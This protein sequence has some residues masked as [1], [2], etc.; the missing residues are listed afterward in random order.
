M[1][2]VIQQSGS[3]ADGKATRDPTFK[4]WF[5]VNGQRGVRCN[6]NQREK[7][8]E[9]RQEMNGGEVQATWIEVQ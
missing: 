1:E 9:V 7:E 3:V 6:G 2:N 4:P 5:G 8:G